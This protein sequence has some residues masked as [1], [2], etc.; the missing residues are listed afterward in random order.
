MK[1]CQCAAYRIVL[2]PTA[3]YISG[4]TSDS[5]VS[6]VVVFKVAD[7]GVGMPALLRHQFPFRL[8]TRVLAV[9]DLW[10]LLQADHVE[11]GLGEMLGGY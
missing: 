4:F 3:L 10:T 8:V 5:E 11:T 9:V 7:V 2:P 6:T 1:R